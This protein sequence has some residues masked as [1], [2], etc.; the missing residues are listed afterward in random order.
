ML[1]LRTQARLAHDTGGL[2]R[3]QA[4]SHEELWHAALRTYGLAPDGALDG[5]GLCRLE[6]SLDSLV[7]QGED[8]WRLLPQVP[9][10]ASQQASRS[11]IPR[12]HLLHQQI[13]DILCERDKLFDKY[14]LTP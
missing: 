5:A 7:H 1:E 9:L 13:K 14:R 4:G 10:A 8:F 12:A 11:D 3:R 6:A 2:I